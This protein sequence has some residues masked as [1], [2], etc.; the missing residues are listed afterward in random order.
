MYRALPTLDWLFFF[1][2]QLL[3]LKHCCR[4]TQTLCHH[5]K[6]KKRGENMPQAFC[7][8][9]SLR[10]IDARCYCFC[11]WILRVLL[12]CM[13]NYIASFPVLLLP[14]SLGHFECACASVMFP[15]LESFL[16]IIVIDFSIVFSFHR[17]PLLFS[18]FVS[19]PDF[20]N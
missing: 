16:S 14:L 15:M 1:L 10:S 4:Y 17:L 11:C 8:A 5:L 19:W 9:P 13:P 18:F 7:F 20:T 3:T 6:K 2:V 12:A